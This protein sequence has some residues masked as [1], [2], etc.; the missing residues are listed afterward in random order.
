M[1]SLFETRLR[2]GIVLAIGVALTFGIAAPAQAGPIGKS[3]LRGAIV[4]AVVGEIAG[5]D[6]AKGA[7]IGA[8]VGAIS[9]AIKKNDRRDK[10]RHRGG[11]KRR[12]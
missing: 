5:G 3:A 8:G 12:R 7:A 9:G 4:G 10:I 1:N 6:A 11:K 2:G